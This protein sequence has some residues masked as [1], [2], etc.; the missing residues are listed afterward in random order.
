MAFTNGNDINILQATDT[1]YVGAG[2][3]NDKYVLSQGNLSASQIITIT[4]ADGSNTLQLIGG[5][6]ITSCKVAS[7]AVQLTLNNSAIVNLLGANTFNFEIGGNPLT[8]TPGTLRDYASFVTNTLGLTSVPTSSSGVVN[9]GENFTINADGTTTTVVPTLSAQ[10]NALHTTNTGTSE[11]LAASTLTVAGLIHSPL[12]KWN[13]S[14]LTYSFNTAIPSDY[15]DDST[16]TTDWSSLN[17][18]E[19]AAAQ[20]VFTK[21][22]D[23]IP[24]A[25]SEV[26]GQS[27]DLRLNVVDMGSNTAGFAYSPPSGSFSSGIDGDVF[28][29]AANR[30][31]GVHYSY[32]A[33]DAGYETMAHEIGH[34][35]GLK[36]PFEQPAVPSGTDNKDY[37]LMSYTNAFNYI[38]QF[39]PSGNSLQSEG[40][41]LAKRDNFGVN[42]IAALHALYGAN[43]QTRT[44][45][46]TYTL[47]TSSY[48][49]LCIWD[50]GG[51]D[52]LDESGASGACTVDLRPG[53]L[54]T[55]DLWPLAQQQ[56]ASIAAAPG[57]SSFI[58]SEYTRMAADLYT[59]HN[60]LSIAH[61]AIIENIKTGSANDTVTDNAVDNTIETGAGNDIVILG[62]G[63][64]DLVNGGTGTDSVTLPVSISQVQ[65]ELQS[66]GSLLLATPTFAARLIGIESV[67]CTDGALTLLG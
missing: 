23:V 47:L 45:N 51:T 27:G 20:S 58:T 22:A 24:V 48:D 60:N 59:G 37:T 29:A 63:G 52:T 7:N 36:H 5:L 17:T 53:T 54:S 10:A 35:M 41:P 38:L 3:G 57:F 15:V 66:D 65:Q 14:T 34:A 8:N 67:N 12:T 1:A 42:D 13:T 9:G 44:G 21:L 40:L 31:A 26:S 6:A 62:S 33:G 56:A 43:T 39:T 11:L 28:L 64:Y 30:T 50:A 25:F 16:L 2:L 32:L 18:A 49:Y 55:V 4:D 61:G 19:K 46:D